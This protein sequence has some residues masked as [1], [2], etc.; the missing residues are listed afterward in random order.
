MGLRQ[1][2]ARAAIRALFRILFRPRLV[3]AP[4]RDGPYL[5]V[6]NHQGWADGFLLS[7]FLPA[8]PRVVFLGDRDGTM[9]IWWHRAIL[10]TMG[11]VIPIDWTTRSDRSAI[12]AALASLAEG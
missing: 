8:E 1:R 9:G 3:G 5:M 7:A 4:P 10:R 11:L 2:I 12:D 6:A